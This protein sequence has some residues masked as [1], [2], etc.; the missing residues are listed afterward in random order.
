MPR[1]FLFTSESVTEGHPDKVCDKI[2]DA[3]LDE[4]LH[5]DPK[6]RTAIEILGS[7][8]DLFIGGEVTSTAEKVDVAK[9]A[10][11]IYRDIGY[12]EPIDVVVKI[13]RQSPDIAQGVDTGGAGDQG[14]MYGYACDETKEL[15]PLAV[16]LAHELTQGLAELRRNDEEAK[17]ILGPDGKAQVSFEKDKLTTLLVS[18]QHAE[19]VSHDELKEFLVRKLIRPLLKI[20]I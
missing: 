14:I 2:A 6:S 3:L 19:S 1:S 16:V 18:T 13:A 9:T 15:M 20:R 17:K 4:F 5:E 7:H 12:K 10:E 8:G 11:K